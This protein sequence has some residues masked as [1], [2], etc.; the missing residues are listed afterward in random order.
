MVVRIIE[1]ECRCYS[2]KKR[3]PYKIVFE[4]IDPKEVDCKRLTEDTDMLIEDFL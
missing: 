4:T 2:T 3:A 1:G